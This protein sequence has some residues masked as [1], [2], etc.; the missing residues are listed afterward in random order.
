MVSYLLSGSR[1][2]I[3]LYLEKTLSHYFNKLGSVPI[4]LK[5][6]KELGQVLGWCHMIGERF[7]VNWTRVSYLR[8]S[9][10]C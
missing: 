8:R 6:L 4:P 10:N 7:R 1:E 3:Q 5:I 9:Y 2:D